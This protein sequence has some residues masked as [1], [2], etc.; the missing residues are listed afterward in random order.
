M[1]EDVM[2]LANENGEEIDLFEGMDA[3]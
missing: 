1:H 3:R 2:A